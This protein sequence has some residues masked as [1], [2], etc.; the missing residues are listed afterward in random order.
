[1]SRALLLASAAVLAFAACS[2]SSTKGFTGD[3]GGSSGSSSGDGGAV[4]DSAS[5]SS[6]APGDGAVPLARGAVDARLTGTG[7]LDRLALK[8]GTISP[9]AVLSSGDPN[10]GDAVTV[11]CTVTAASGAYSVSFGVASNVSF[12]VRGTTDKPSAVLSNDTTQYS[13]DTCTVTTSD[14]ALDHVLG[15]IKCTPTTVGS[16]S[17]GNPAPSPCELDADFAVYGCV[18]H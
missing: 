14:V 6:G 8:F 16:G 1:M 4:T 11:A 15:S 7:C 5:T 2:S 10:G 17:S 12:G 9:L 3:D 18:A 13:A